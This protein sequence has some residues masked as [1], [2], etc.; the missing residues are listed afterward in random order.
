MDRATALQVVKEHV[1]SKN[2][3]KHMLAAE[4]IMRQ[5]ALHFQEDVELWGLAGLVHDI[6][7]AKT[8]D[9]PE[10][11]A[12][13]GAEILESLGVESAIIQAVLGHA[14]KGPRLTLMDKA[15]YATD[16][17]TGL[18]VAAAL[19]HP[20]KRLASIDVG[21]VLNR[22]GEKSFARGADRE[23]I[24]SCADFGMELEDFIALGLRAMQGISGDLGL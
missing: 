7:Y 20:D 21:F 3:I 1:Q 19:I 13:V 10:R 2:L 6:D 15:L 9:E 22:F 18:L 17:L 4:A 8:A 12:L 24:S 16:P 11:H 14:D 5:L 23:A